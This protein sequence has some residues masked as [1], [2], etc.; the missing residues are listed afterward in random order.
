MRQRMY[1]ENVGGNWGLPAGYMEAATAPGRNIAAGIS[2]FGQSIGSAIEQYQKN[3]ADGEEADAA[4]G[5][6]AK[7]YEQSL[8]ARGKELTPEQM[9]MAE[10]WSKSPNL[11]LG[12]KRAVLADIYLALGRYDKETAREDMLQARAEANRL[13]NEQFLFQ[14]NSFDRQFE[15][16]VS[17]D[18]HNNARDFRADELA[19]R[20]YNLTR[21]T[22]DNA[23]ADRAATLNNLG[24][25]PGSGIP[26]A[27][28]LESMRQFHNPPPPPGTPMG[29]PGLPNYVG[30]VQGVGGGIGMYPKPGQAGVTPKPTV[31]VTT[32]DGTDGSP[33]V[34]R[35]LTEEQYAAYLNAN[36]RAADAETKK[37]ENSLAQLL[38]AKAAGK[39]KVDGDQL[40]GGGGVDTNPLWG[41]ISID[42]GIDAVRL[43]L[44]PTGAPAAGAMDGVHMPRTQKEFD[45]LPQGARYKNLKDGKTYIKN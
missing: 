23:S 5:L 32:G 27:Q 35:E 43:R 14:Q 13:A 21:L 38:A 31:T 41:A 8:T 18:T 19:G 40:L 25:P 22:A 42:K 4:I 9:V 24:M 11:S 30:V 2:S 44:N 34:Q 45:A 20:Y 10:K 36:P 28:V 26:N 12:G 39:T 33:R 15:R 37:W 17:Q 1:S 7:Q 16:Q 3:K 6:A 29:V